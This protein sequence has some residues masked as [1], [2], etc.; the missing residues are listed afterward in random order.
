MQGSRVSAEWTEA[1]VCSKSI[2]S[3]LV[4]ERHFCEATPG[5]VVKPIC[6]IGLREGKC[7]WL[8]QD[9][10]HPEHPSV[11]NSLSVKQKLTPFLAGAA[12]LA[13]VAAG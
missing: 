8:D 11:V 4:S 5:Y 10:P 13:G 6:T 3:Q 2:C 12:G 7:L 9:T 1:A